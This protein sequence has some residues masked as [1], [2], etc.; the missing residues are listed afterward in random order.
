MMNPKKNR[1]P[2]SLEEIRRHNKMTTW[3]RLEHK[4][5]WNV[6]D[7]LEDEHKIVSILL[8]IAITAATAAMIGWAFLHPF[9]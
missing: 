8:G 4:H 6:F 9:G 2:Y 5:G 1:K 7:W 3:Q